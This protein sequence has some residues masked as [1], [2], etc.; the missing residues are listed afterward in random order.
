[1]L[2]QGSPNPG[3]ATPQA[4]RKICICLDLAERRW[5]CWGC[6]QV[7]GGGMHLGD[8]RREIVKR[9]GS[10]TEELLNRCHRT[11]ADSSRL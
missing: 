3:L 4:E 9:Y 2:S 7:F 10:G 5:F 8:E 6:G 1:M 11:G